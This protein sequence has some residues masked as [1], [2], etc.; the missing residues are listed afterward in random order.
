MNE[1]RA[2]SAQASVDRTGRRP[3]QASVKVREIADALRCVSLD[4]SCADGM[5]DHLYLTQTQSEM[6]AEL[7]IRALATPTE[8]MLRVG[9]EDVDLSKAEAQQVW[10]AM[11]RETLR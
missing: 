3:R 6:L 1:D 2:D 5:S 9:V 11:C 10:E 4:I 7:A 8:E